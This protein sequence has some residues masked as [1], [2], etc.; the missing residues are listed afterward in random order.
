LESK[1]QKKTKKAKK[2]KNAFFVIKIDNGFG[3]MIRK[4][5]KQTRQAK[6]KAMTMAP[7][8]LLLLVLLIT[9]IIMS[10]A[11]VDSMAS[12]EYEQICNVLKES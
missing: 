11:A 9:F 10:F 4:R 5:D 2:S 3:V 6:A 8:D 12:D 1:K 7:L